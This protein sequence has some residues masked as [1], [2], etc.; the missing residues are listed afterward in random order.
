MEN[1]VENDTL[2]DNMAD[3][4]MADYMRWYWQCTVL[5]ITPPGA[6]SQIREGFQG[7]GST[8][9]LLVTYLLESHYV[10]FSELEIVMFSTNFF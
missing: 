3:I 7:E 8:A 6:S 2:V 10:M 1:H 4:P 5:Y 9:E